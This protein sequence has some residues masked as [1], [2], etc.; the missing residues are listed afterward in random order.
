[1]SNTNNTITTMIKSLSNEQIFDRGLY[2]KYSKRKLCRLLRALYG[3]NI[4]F[5]KLVMWIKIKGK[6]IDSIVVWDL[7]LFKKLCP[8]KNWDRFTIYHG[9]SLEVLQFLQKAGM[10]MNNQIFQDQIPNGDMTILKWLAEQ[11]TIRLT[12]H[13]FREAVINDNLDIVKWMFEMGCENSSGAFMSAAELGNI[14]MLEFLRK[15]GCRMT[16]QA[17]YCAVR[18][19]KWDAMEWLIKAGCPMNNC[20]TSNLSKEENYPL[21]QRF[22]NLGCPMCDTT[23]DNVIAQGNLPILKSLLDGNDGPICPISVGS[24]DTAAQCGHLH[25]MKWLYN[26]LGFKG[27]HP[28]IEA[29]EFG[30]LENIKWLHSIGCEPSYWTYKRA[31]EC[32]KAEIVNW[33]L[34]IGCPTTINQVKL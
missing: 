10:V 22:R 12:P 20:I 4:R 27:R 5:P 29:A 3:D 7:F 19:K 14:L 33:L 8:K 17:L 23:T 13:L 25:I 1:M 18:Y 32:G 24:F 11:P 9:C 15:I 21:L 6:N 34:S 28:M 30:N 2:V 16:G 26:N 31:V